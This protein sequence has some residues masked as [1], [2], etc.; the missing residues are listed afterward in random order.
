MRITIEPTVQPEDFIAVSVA[1]ADDAEGIDAIVQMVRAAL[2]AWGYSD[3]SISDAFG[4]AY[5]APG[6]LSKK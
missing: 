3:A 1:S 6:T 2:L 5:R 4:G